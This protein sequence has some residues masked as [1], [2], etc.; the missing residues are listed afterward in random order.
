MLYETL[1]IASQCSSPLS[2]HP[3]LSCP[4]HNLRCKRH[5]ILPLLQAPG[6]TVHM[7][8]HHTYPHCPSGRG[9]VWQGMA[10]ASRGLTEDKPIPHVHPRTVSGLGILRWANVSALQGPGSRHHS[11]V[12][13]SR[14]EHLRRKEV[15]TSNPSLRTREKV[16]AAMCQHAR[17]QMWPFVRGFF[18]VCLET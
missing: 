13:S 17:A 7:C 11:P 6:V 18:R 3:H 10:A 16:M 2:P 15:L 14:D 5:V 1:V 12:S 8:R 4:N 9:S